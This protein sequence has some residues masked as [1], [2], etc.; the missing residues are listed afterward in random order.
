MWLSNTFSHHKVINMVRMNQDKEKKDSKSGIV[1]C[2]N[3]LTIKFVGGISD[4]C[5]CLCS[6]NYWTVCLCCEVSS[7]SHRSNKNKQ[8]FFSTYFRDCKLHDINHTL[9]MN[10]T[11]TPN[12]ENLISSKTQ[13]ITNHNNSTQSHMTDPKLNSVKHLDISM[14]KFIGESCWKKV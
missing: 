3:D 12:C 13:S 14:K 8:W 9:L 1:L 4:M 6:C 5:R 11:G 7:K 10:N 2:R